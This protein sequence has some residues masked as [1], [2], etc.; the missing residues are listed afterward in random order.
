ML[1]VKI[2]RGNLEQRQQKRKGLMFSELKKFCLL[3]APNKLLIW[4]IVYYVTI[5][6]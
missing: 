5:G 2:T 6:N 4:G 1:E 3:L